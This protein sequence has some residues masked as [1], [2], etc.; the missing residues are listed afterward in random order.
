MRRK[1]LRRH[2]ELIGLKPSFTILD[3]DDQIRLLKQLMEAENID[4]KKWPARMLLSIIERWK[5]R[6]LTP[7]KLKP[8]EAGDAANGRILTDT[9]GNP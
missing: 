2:A 3:T 7:D 1:I 6:A 9:A 5:D 4:S 8:E